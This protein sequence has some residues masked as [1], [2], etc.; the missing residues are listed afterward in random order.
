MPRDT[1]N[2]PK[3]IKES[4]VIVHAICWDINGIKQN[5][6]GKKSRYVKQ[7]CTFFWLMFIEN[8]ENRADYCVDWKEKNTKI[9]SLVKRRQTHHYNERVRARIQ[10]EQRQLSLVSTQWKHGIQGKAAKFRL[11]HE[12]CVHFKN[13]LWMCLRKNANVLWSSTTHM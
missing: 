13:T 10:G 11:K 7:R 12:K 3:G 4:N 5:K 9:I 1:S 8:G 6:R 2:K